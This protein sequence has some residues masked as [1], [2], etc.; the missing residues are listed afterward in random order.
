MILKEQIRAARAYL[1]MS[2]I[3]LSDLSGV[4]Y[5]SLRKIE[6]GFGYLNCS[7]VNYFKLQKT[8]TDHGIVFIVNEEPGIQYVESQDTSGRIKNFTKK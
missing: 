7:T 4:P 3:E 2:L 1:Q 6:K 5:D 8:L